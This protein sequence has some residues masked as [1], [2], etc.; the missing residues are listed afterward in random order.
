MTDNDERLVAGD[1]AR[2]ATSTATQTMLAHQFHQRAGRL[3]TPDELAA[4]VE[5]YRVAYLAIARDR[6]ISG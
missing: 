1:A 5:Q 6:L 2:S 4:E 3:P